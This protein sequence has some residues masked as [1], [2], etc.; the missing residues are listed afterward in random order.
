MK[1]HIF[2]TFFSILAP[3]TYFSH[4]LALHPHQK[5]QF[6]PGILLEIIEVLFFLI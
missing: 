3:N 5:V 4:T 1:S 2:I 6:Q